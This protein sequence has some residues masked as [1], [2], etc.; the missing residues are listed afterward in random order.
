[1]NYFAN[2][3]RIIAMLYP[4]YS[5]HKLY[6]RFFFDRINVFNLNINFILID[7]LVLLIS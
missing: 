3:S 2:I 6:L 4:Y 1:M 7:I 5:K